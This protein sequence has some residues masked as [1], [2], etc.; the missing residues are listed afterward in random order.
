MN[1]HINALSAIS[2]AGGALLEPLTHSTAMELNLIE[3]LAG[4][5]ARTAIEE[6]EYSKAGVRIRLQRGNAAAQATQTEA[7]HDAREPVPG[8]TSTQLP[9]PAPTSPVSLHPVVAGMSGTF[10]GA[11]APGVAP[12]VKVGDTVQE[13]QVLAVVEAM[14]MLNQIEAD[15]GGRIVRVALEDGMAVTPATVL[16]DIEPAANAH[17]ENADD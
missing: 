2:H 15:I 10:H 17:G 12:F 16:F 14:K 9:P 3:Q 8:L 6:L 7:R 1:T 11:P 5:M 4:V 13:G